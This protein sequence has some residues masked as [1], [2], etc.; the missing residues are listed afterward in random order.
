MRIA[1]NPFG[2]LARL[3]SYEEG[4]DFLARMKKGEQSLYLTFTHRER[5]AFLSWVMFGGNR[6]E[7]FF[8]LIRQLNA[9]TRPVPSEKAR[10]AV[11]EI[12][13]GVADYLLLGLP[14]AFRIVFHS[15]REKYNAVSALSEGHLNR[16]LKGVLGGLMLVFGTVSFALETVRA[17]IGGVLMLPVFFGM[18]LASAIAKRKMLKTDAVDLNAPSSAVGVPAPSKIEEWAQACTS[19]E[20]S[21]TMLVPFGSAYLNSRT[22]CAGDDNSQLLSPEP[23]SFQIGG[24]ASGA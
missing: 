12:R 19:N 11:Q 6:A 15:C 10:S 4:D 5:L 22:Q 8:E 3:P 21:P 16:F 14:A 17:L 20:D 24:R 1:M 23:G 9:R 18:T 7:V 2:L 13:F